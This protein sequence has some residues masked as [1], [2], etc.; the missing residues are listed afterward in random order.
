[1]SSLDSFSMLMLVSSPLIWNIEW[2]Y[3]VG[4][5]SKGSKCCWLKKQMYPSTCT[6][7]RPCT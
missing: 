3:I 6:V 2:C 5:K 4:W 1:M 7:L